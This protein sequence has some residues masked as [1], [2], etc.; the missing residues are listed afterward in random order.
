MSQEVINDRYDNNKEKAKNS[1]EKQ[2]K[3]DTIKA[4][5]DKDNWIETQTSIDVIT[6]DIES[7]R[8]EDLK[9]SIDKILEEKLRYDFLDTTTKN[10]VKL[11]IID[12]IIKSPIA[13]KLNGIWIELAEFFNDL[14]EWNLDQIQKLI[15]N[16]SE[17]PEIEWKVKDVIDYFNDIIKEYDNKF[18]EIKEKLENNIPPIKDPKQQQAIISNIDAFRDPNKVNEIKNLKVDEIDLTKTIKKEITDE[19]KQKLAEHI[20]NLKEN[21]KKIDLKLKIWDEI[22]EW[23]FNIIDWWW[24]IW[25]WIKNITEFLLNIPFLWKFI[26]IFLWLDPKNSTESLNEALKSHQI[27]KWLKVLWKTK[28]KSW[29]EPFQDIDLSKLQTNLLK[30]ELKELEK[31]FPELNKENSSDFWTKA[32]KEWYQK[33]NWVKIKFEMT[34]EQ[35]KDNK[36]DNKEFREILKNWIEK[37]K[38]ETKEKELETEKEEKKEKINNINQ[39]INEISKDI[40]DKEKQIRNINDIINKNYEK[41]KHWDDVFNIWDI[42]DIKIEN[43]INNEWNDFW[44]IIGEEIWESDYNR[45]PQKDKE[46]LN[47][48]FSLIKEYCKDKGISGKSELKN[49][50][51]ENATWFNNFLSEKNKKLRE[52]KNKKI[53]EKNKKEKE[54]TEIK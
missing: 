41:I 53:E 44:I 22:S 4:E 20:F 10:I 32:F 54:K 7:P 45:L 43:I 2:Q 25:E 47:T 49:F 17:K 26:A 40:K 46:L 18:K 38:L 5:L 39:Q 12:E 37:Y 8:F 30:K 16:K 28:E 52:E 11:W 42:N 33:E 13:W 19:E 48:L 24:K 31:E 9:D 1:H 34:D 23:F 36:I 27:L 14:I 21:F 3:I 29:T 50:L 6:K 51:K 15:N 35:K